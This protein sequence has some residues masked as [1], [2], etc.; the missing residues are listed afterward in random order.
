MKIE[1][2]APLPRNMIDVLDAAGIDTAGI[3]RSVGVTVE[4]LETGVTRAQADAFVMRALPFSSDPAFG[5]KLGASLKS[6]RFSLVGLTM[7]MCRDLAAA[8]RQIARF[9][10]LV[11]GDPCTVTEKDGTITLCY[12]P[13]IAGRPYNRMK[14]DMQ[15]MSM[16]SFADK[17]TQE[18]IEP[19]RVRISAQRPPWWERYDEA[20]RCRVEFAAGEDCITFARRDASHNLVSANADLMPVMERQAEMALAQTGDRCLAER[21]REVVDGTMSQREPTIAAVAAAM[22]MSA[23]TLQRRLSDNGI[24]FNLLVDQVR[25]EAAEAHLARG[26]VNFVELAFLLGFSDPNSFFRAFKRWT[27]TTPSLYRSRVGE[28][29]SRRAATR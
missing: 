28:A 25:R 11:W 4:D 9:N 6:E 24:R 22:R 3:A 8:S 1:P 21:V 20:F 7:M 14:L 29:Q 18:R 2:T 26:S 10:A 13:L 19:L 17:F 15:L 16:L 12:T 27:G 23:R 5:L